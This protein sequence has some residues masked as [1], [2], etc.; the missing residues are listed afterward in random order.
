MTLL[1]NGVQVIRETLLLTTSLAVAMRELPVQNATRKTD[2]WHSDY[3]ANPSQLR[4]RDHFTQWGHC[5][6]YGESLHANLCANNVSQVSHVDSDVEGSRALM[7]RRYRTRLR[8]YAGEWRCILHCKL[9]LLWHI[10]RFR[11]NTIR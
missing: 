3:V 10:V 2:G 7:L 11:L 6:F 5:Q 9:Q 1:H 8:T 4:L